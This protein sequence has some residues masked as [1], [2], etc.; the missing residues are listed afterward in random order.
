MLR[1]TVLFIFFAFI[2]FPAAGE[3]IYL[4]PSAF[5][6]AGDF[7]GIAGTGYGIFASYDTVLEKRY[8]VGIT[9]GYIYFPGEYES[10]TGMQKI[11]NYSIIP[12]MFKAAYIFKLTSAAS[13]TPTAEFGAAQVQMNY[14]T[15]SQSTGLLTEKTSAGFEP[16]AIGTLNFDYKVTDRVFTGINCGYGIIPEDKGNISFFQAGVAIGRR[17]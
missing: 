3:Y 16:I 17:F 15:R 12:L 10:I 7:S 9:A 6:P 4:K 14:V 13:I 11:D 8:R 2:A 1:K 5:I